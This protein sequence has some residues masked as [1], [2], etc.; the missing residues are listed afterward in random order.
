MWLKNNYDGMW[1]LVAPDIK[2]TTVGT[3]LAKLKAFHITGFS[4]TERQKSMWHRGTFWI[5]LYLTKSFQAQNLLVPSSGEWIYLEPL[6]WCTWNLYSVLYIVERHSSAHASLKHREN[7]IC[8]DISF[9][10]KCVEQVAGYMIVFNS[11][12]FSLVVFSTYLNRH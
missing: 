8:S 1:K 6:L 3:A 2:V 4:E 5:F 12:K 7:H 9:F 10:F 11:K